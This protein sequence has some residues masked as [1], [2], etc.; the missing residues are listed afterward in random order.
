MS[1]IRTTVTL[2]PAIR[3]EVERRREGS[4]RSL[5]EEVEA[6]LRRAL[7]QPDG[8][9]MLL[10]RIDDGLLGWLRALVRGPGFFGNLNQTTVYLIRCALHDL[11]KNDIWFAATV[12]HLP[13]PTRTHLIDTPKYQSLL[14]AAKDPLDSARRSG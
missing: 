11:L 3:D 2:S 6:L 12:P 13:E 10:L 8:D 7:D 9:E 4:G 14:R 5:S 1:G